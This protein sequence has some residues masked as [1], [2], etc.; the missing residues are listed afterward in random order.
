MTYMRRKKVNN[1]KET[2]THALVNARAH[3]HIHQQLHITWMKMWRN[4][5]I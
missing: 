2:N 5:T 3:V 4:H 1:G